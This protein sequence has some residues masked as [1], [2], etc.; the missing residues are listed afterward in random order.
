V[1]N[2]TADRRGVR[3]PPRR[4]AARR[5]PRTPGERPQIERGS[6]G[7]TGQ[8]EPFEPSGRRE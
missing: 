2:V 8:I 1:P 6:A 5:P 7:G 4:V 3:P